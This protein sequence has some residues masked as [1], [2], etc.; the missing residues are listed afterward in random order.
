[1]VLFC[2]SM[3]SS[4]RVSVIV[5]RLS[6]HHPQST[7][8]SCTCVCL[9]YALQTF[10]HKPVVSKWF[11][12]SV[13]VCVCVCECVRMC[14]WCVCVCVSVCGCVCMCVYVCVRVCVCVCAHVRACACVCLCV[15]E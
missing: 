9:R 12:V 7:H 3:G 5:V 8:F 10:I 4:F 15:C 11:H 1:M 14:V 13:C 6:V 2:R